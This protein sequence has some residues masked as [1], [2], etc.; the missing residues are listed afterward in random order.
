[1]VF[2]CGGSERES[3]RTLWIWCKPY[4]VLREGCKSSSG[5]CSKCF[6][7]SHFSDPHFD[8]KET[9]LSF[10]FCIKITSS[11]KAYNEG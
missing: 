9:I 1:M 10:W 8:F 5:F 4:M 11:F 6:Y 7:L 3:Q 2:E